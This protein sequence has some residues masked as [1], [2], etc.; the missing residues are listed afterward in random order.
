MM[1]KV[2]GTIKPLPAVEL[3]GTEKQVKWASE[4]RAKAANVL[5]QE[6]VLREQYEV[7]NML[8]GGK[9][10]IKSRPVQRI[11]E[12]LKSEEGIKAYLESLPDFLV[13]STIKS[14]NDALDRYARFAEIMSNSSAKF[15]IDNRDNQEP[16]YMF[17]LFKQYINTGV[18][19]F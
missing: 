6:C 16:N 14:M 12:A 4:I 7:T 1:E 15:W 11:I 13:E 3:E 10:E 19:R 17:M 8:P 2:K 18:K 5:L 9:T